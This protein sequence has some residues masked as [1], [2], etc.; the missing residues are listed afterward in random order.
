MSEKIV[1]ADALA[2][3]AQE[4][5]ASGKRLVF[6]NGCFDVLHV[7]HVRYL[8]AARALGDYLAVGING[9][10]SVRELKGEG[11]PLNNERDR[12]ALVAALAAVDYVVIFSET[13]ASQLLSQI[14]P[15][16]YV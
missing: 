1:T 15:A 13:R 16:I 8:E 4:I 5:R 7:G 2:A 10:G 6:T 14:C 9:D 12:A 11:R 3:I